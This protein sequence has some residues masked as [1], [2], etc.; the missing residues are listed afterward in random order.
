MYLRNA[1]LLCPVGLLSLVSLMLPI[2]AYAQADSPVLEE[3]IVTANKRN[4][5][6]Q[7]VPISIGV[8]GGELVEQY[9]I[10][11]LRD[12]QNFVPNLTVQRTFGNWAVR[13][14]GLGSGVTNL[15]FDSS[16][17]IFNDGVYC[18]RSRCL[19]SAYMD[20]DRIEVARGPQGA[21]FGRSTIAG[22]LS[23]HS[24]KPQD[25]FEGYI[26]G[27][28]ELEDGGYTSAVMITGPFAD[29]VRGRL[30]VKVKNLDGWINNPAGKNGE[31]EQDSLALRASLEWD[32][33]DNTGLYLKVEHFNVDLT[34]RTNQLVGNGGLFGRLSLHPD[35]EFR[36]D[37]TRV[38]ST[39]AGV[40]DFDDSESISYTLQ[41]DTQLGGH[42]FLKMKQQKILKRVPRYFLP[43]VLS[44]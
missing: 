14:R 2:F 13:I 1:G 9:D 20:V 36:R 4:E 30:A 10:A 31:P 17:S 21:L 43:A 44:V 37:T 16:V 27:G 19:E 5:S 3:V 26:R 11:D 7:D 41:F 33:N 42:T 24:A 22:A 28:V 29:N 15:A 35:K 8:V 39:G 18:G 23:V 38:V 34:G 6:L 12:L 40:E 25:S 32:I